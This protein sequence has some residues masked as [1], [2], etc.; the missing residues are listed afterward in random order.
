MTGWDINPRVLGVVPKEAQI[1]TLQGFHF[2]TDGQ[3]M[4]V[5]KGVPDA[6]LAVLLD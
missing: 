6:H 4:A 1:G 5:P 3:Y 2:V